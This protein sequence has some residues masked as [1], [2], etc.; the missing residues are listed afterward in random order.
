MGKLF[1]EKFKKK[2]LVFLAAPKDNKKA[3]ATG[4]VIVSR[5]ENI[6]GSFSS[7]WHGLLGMPPFFADDG[8]YENGTLER[9][10]AN[11]DW[12]WE[13]KESLG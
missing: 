1:I 8:I 9:T 4:D 3:F 13:M 12:E 5:N 11:L 7:A 6:D 2:T 10:V